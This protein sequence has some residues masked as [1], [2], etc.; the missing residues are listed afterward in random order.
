[1]LAPDG[2]H[3]TSPTGGTTSADTIAAIV[4]ARGIYRPTMIARHHRDPDLPTDEII[5]LG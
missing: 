1:V 3:S 5:P 2:P 4:T